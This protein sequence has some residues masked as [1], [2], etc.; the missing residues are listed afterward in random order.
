MYLFYFSK[1]VLNFVSVFTD[2]ACLS[3]NRNLNC[4]VADT[5]CT[6]RSAYLFHSSR[7]NQRLNLNALQVDKIQDYISLH[8]AKYLS[9]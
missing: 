6:Q 5:N 3:I 9:P 7:F 2:P 1:T 4:F 8:H